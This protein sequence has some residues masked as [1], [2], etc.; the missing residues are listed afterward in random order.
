MPTSSEIRET[1][2]T[3]I[4]MMCDSDIDG[5]VSLFAEDATAEDPVGGAVQEGI[6]AIGKFYGMTAPALQVEL[7][8]PICVAGNNAAFLL[9]AQLTMGGNVQY[10]DAT[11]VMIFNDEGQITSMRAFWDPSEMRAEP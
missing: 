4:K 10:L 5:I 2:H 3:Y 8:G 1:I 9:L 7:K 6:E 11:D